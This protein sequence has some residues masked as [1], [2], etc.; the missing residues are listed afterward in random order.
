MTRLGIDIGG[1]FTDL[2]GVIPATGELFHIKALSTPEQPAQGVLDALDRSGLRLEE[3]SLLVHGTTI[4]INAIIEGKGAPTG[5]VATEGFRDIL[6]LRRGARTH[7]LDPL[8]DKP[9]TFVPRRWRTEVG[10]RTRWDGEIQRPLD[11]GQ[12]VKAVESLVGEGVQSVAVCLLN[13]YANSANEQRI[14]EI[15]LG[16]FPELYYTLSSKLV[17]EMREFE[18]TSTTALNAYIQPVV[19]RYLSKMESELREL[20]LKTGLQLMQSNGGL[21]TA[22]E[23][24]NRPVHILESGPAGGCIAAVHLGE[25][26]GAGNLI[27]LDMGGT[28]AKASVIEDGRPLT[29]VEYELFEEPDKPGSGW[30]IRVPMI[31]IVE[32]G[33]GGGS[34]AWLDHGNTLQVGPQSSGASPGPVSY[35]RGGMDPTI[36]DANA[37]L[38]RLVALLGG[39]FPLDAERARRAM[40]ERIA[41]P[42]GISVEEA[43]TGILQISNSK[44]ADLIREVTIARGRDPRDFGLIVYGGAGPLVAG[45]VIRELG[46]SKA[47]IPPAP[48]NFSALGLI[49][50]DII[51]DVV[52]TY[53][54]DQQQVDLERLNNLYY[55]ME[56]EL[57][58]RLRHEG[59]APE[60][61]VLQ[62]SADLKYK[63][64]FHLVNL[65]VKAGFLAPDDLAV[66]RE[67]FE[68]EHLRLYTYRSEGEPTDLVNVRVRG[69]G[70]LGRPE[71]PLL[72]VDTA[73]KAFTNTRPVYF[74]EAG[75][76]LDCTIYQRKRLGSGSTLAGPAIVEE[77]TST[78]LVPPGFDARVDDY[79]NIILSI[80]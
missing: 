39:T 23:A 12:V 9:P 8:M 31:D 44:I 60:N 77:N 55:E 25:L 78:T 4:A 65:P 32:I 10:E 7:L 29:T 16:E 57:E 30:P 53:I 71:L 20:G 24:V 46:I 11:E 58:A 42:L 56:T 47:I 41:G 27:T 38:G 74:R 19:H 73:S 63:G 45:D 15:I 54:W 6:E 26:V 18:R 43:A 1:T 68:Q 14:G 37:I 35:S 28:T 36:T 21:M 66:L 61:L 40:E 80:S 2:T 59:V 79:G 69:R 34:I 72:G 51:H 5:I 13:S 48:G 76:P 33:A 3:V 64:Q 17:P 22:E 62:R 70:V 75:G 67:A 49:S 52:R 50:T